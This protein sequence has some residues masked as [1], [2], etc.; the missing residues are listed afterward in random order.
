M[1]TKSSNANPRSRFA[2][3]F[4]PVRLKFAS[5]FVFVHFVSL[6]VNS[7]PSVTSLWRTAHNLARVAI[8][9]RFPIT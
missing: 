9:E 4:L 6:F 3:M 7:V 1:V 5:S 2:F 8:P